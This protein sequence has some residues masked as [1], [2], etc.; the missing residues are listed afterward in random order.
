M[1]E[2]TTLI[3]FPC[4]FPIKIIGINAAQFKQEITDIVVKHFPETKENAIVYKD[5]GQGNYLAITA[6][7]YA[8]DQNTLDALY[9]D[10]SSHPMVKMVL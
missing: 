10:L 7:V 4:H 8:L 6:T 5:S 9:Q 1:T 2:K 3:E